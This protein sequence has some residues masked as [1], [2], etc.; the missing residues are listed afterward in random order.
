MRNRQLSKCD[1]AAGGK[2]AQRTGPGILFLTTH[3]YST[4]GGIPEYANRLLDVFEDYTRDGRGCVCLAFVGKDARAE[5]EA[6]KTTS[7]G[8]QAFGSKV[9]FLVGSLRTAFALRPEITIA[10]H[11]GLAPVAMLI[12]LFTA[13]RKYA[14]VLHGIEAWVRAEWKD[15]LA[16]RYAHMVIATTRYTA[17]KFTSANSVN[18]HNVRIVPL[19]LG[20]REIP[21][22]PP[23]MPSGVMRI[24]TVGRLKADERYKG[25]D[26][27]ISAIANLRAAGMP[28]ALDVVGTGDDLERYK[29]LAQECGIAGHVQFHG[30]VGESRLQELYARC[31]IFAMPSKGE[32]FGLVFLEAMRHGKPC[33]GGNHGGTPEVIEHGVTGYLVNHGDVERLGHLIWI[34]AESPELRARMGRDA[35]QKVRARYLFTSFSENWR[36]LLDELR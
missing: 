7:F 21:E 17:S 5:M 24:L 6:H 31:D 4:K 19:A 20:I 13:T 26:T 33:I 32:G 25:V 15:R 11:L 22:I 12:N 35:Q 27:L 29:D 9:A 8:F 34:L 28:V 1:F 16:A 14:I 3:I 36:G 18:P 10:A 30:R 23:S 2:P